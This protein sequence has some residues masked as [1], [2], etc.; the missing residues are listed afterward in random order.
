[1]EGERRI[2]VAV[3]FSACSKKALI[4]ALDNLVRDGDHLVLVDVQPEGNYEE[5]EMQLWAL[6]GS[7]MFSISILF[8]S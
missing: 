8:L 4:W 5:G 6:T 3:D 7:R 2:G 1:M